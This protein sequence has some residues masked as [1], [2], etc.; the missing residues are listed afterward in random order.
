MKRVA[1]LFISCFNH[2]DDNNK[3]D[4]DDDDD[5]DTKKSLCFALCRVITRS[6]H[7]PLLQYC[8][9]TLSSSPSSLSILLKPYFY[10]ILQDQANGSSKGMVYSTAAS[11]LLGTDNDN[12]NNYDVEEIVNLFLKCTILGNKFASHDTVVPLARPFLSTLS[13]PIIDTVIVPTCE[14]KL[15]AN[16]EGCLETIH[17]ILSCLDTSGIVLQEEA[18][19]NLTSLAIKQF[20]SSSKQHMKL[21]ASQ[22]LV[23]VAHLS[24]SCDNIVTQLCNAL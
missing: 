21:L 15:R 22:F 1:S 18:T 17:A 3:N 8:C 20:K 19:T 16:P 13:Q 14:L 4:D 2:M 24:S 5:D 7:L 9:Q 23:Q 10:S 6:N 12:K 11:I